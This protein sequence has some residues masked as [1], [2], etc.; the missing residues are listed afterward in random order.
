MSATFA[1]LPD[2]PGPVHHD[3]RVKQKAPWCFR[4][5]TRTATSVEVTYHRFRYRG[6][7]EAARAAM[8]PDHK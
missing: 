3:P 5:V 2:G 8:L 7:A 1:Q 4:V 6:D